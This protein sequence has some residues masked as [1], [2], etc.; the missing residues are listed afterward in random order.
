MGKLPAALPR[1]DAAGSFPIRGAWSHFDT[2]GR[3]RDLQ[4]FFMTA[5]SPPEKRRPGD[6]PL[7]RTRG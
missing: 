2:S 1:D 5:P 4:S 6:F 7:S 3:L